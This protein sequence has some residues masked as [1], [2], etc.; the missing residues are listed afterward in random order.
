MMGEAPGHAHSSDGAE[1]SEAAGTN[2][3][4]HGSI[5]IRGP[6]QMLDHSVLHDPNYIVEGSRN[7]TGVLLGEDACLSE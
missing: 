6:H 3:D 2:D 4:A 7:D 5:P 1:Y